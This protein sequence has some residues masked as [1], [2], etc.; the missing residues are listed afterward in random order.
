M[1]S[2]FQ[3]IAHHFLK[4]ATTKSLTSS[5]SK[6]S[7]NII[8]H[9]H[10]NGTYSLAAFNRSFFK[11]LHDNK[12]SKVFVQPVEG[13]ETD[14]IKNV[15]HRYKK[16]LQTDLSWHLFKKEIDANANKIIVY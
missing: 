14:D 10:I 16:W 11:A 8:G 7:P 15:P 5:F 13:T 1:F 12:S 9:G 3:K 2:I 6:P 4:K